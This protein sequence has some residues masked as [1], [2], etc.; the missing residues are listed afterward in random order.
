[1]TRRLV[2][3]CLLASPFLLGAVG[4]VGGPQVISANGSVNGLANSVRSQQPGEVVPATAIKLP[5]TTLADGT[6]AVRAVAYVNNSPVYENEWRDAVNQRAR[7][8][9]ALEE[10]ERSQKRKLVEQQELD[11]LIER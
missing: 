9:A 4:C 3:G 6:V 7:E 10:P 8:F 5:P 11:K 2:R 1:M